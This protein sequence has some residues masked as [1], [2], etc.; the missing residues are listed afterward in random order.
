M[1][2]S[3]RVGSGPWKL[4]AAALAAL[5]ALAG[6]HAAADVVIADFE[7]DPP[8]YNNEDGFTANTPGGVLTSVNNVTGDPN[9]A[10]WWMQITVPTNALTWYQTFNEKARN[11]ALSQENYNTHQYIAFDLIVP[12]SYVNNTLGLVYVVQGDGQGWTQP[13]A[14]IIDIPAKDTK[15]HVQLDLERLQPVATTT[16]WWQTFM[17]WQPGEPPEGTPATPQTFYVDNLTFVS[18]PANSPSLYFR[19]G[20]G[21]WNSAGSWRFSLIPNSPGA[22]AILGARPTAP[23]T[24]VTETAVTIGTLRFDNANT[25]QIAGNGTLNVQVASGTG[26][27]EVLQGSHKINLPINFHSSTNITVPTGS[28]LTIGDPMVVKTGATVTKSGTVLIEAPLT[29]E[30]GGVLNLGNGVSSLYKAPTLGT[31]AKVNITGSGVNVLEGNL[32]TVT[33]QIKTALENGGNFDWQGPGIGSTRAF[34]QNQTAGSFLYGLGVV[35]NDLAQVGGSGPIYTTFNGQS[36]ASDDVL[37][38]FTYFGDADLSGSI[39]ATDYS[40]IDNGYV[41]TLSGWINGDFDYSGTIDATDYALID[42]AYV[43]QAGPLA[44]ALIAEHTRMFGGEYLAALRAIQS[45]VIPEPA[46]LSLLAL[47]AWSLKRCRRTVGGA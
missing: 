36:V 43:N 25:Y 39:D 21:D 7:A 27:I 13:P 34:Q 4:R 16:G 11:P 26:L 41:N 32:A 5:G 14:Y 18:P 2:S 17:H 38:K 28:T 8:I 40:L 29:I 22:V 15:F 35:L 47:G 24:V 20:I 30:P 10:N 19:T 1:S 6:G 23:T 45:G 3:S 12:S 9:P 33:A 44:E 37:V 31:G 42:N 46:S